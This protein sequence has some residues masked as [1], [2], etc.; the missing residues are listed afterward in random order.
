MENEINK[1]ILSTNGT[2]EKILIRKAS[3]NFKLIRVA[4]GFELCE[5]ARLLYISSGF[6]SQ[7]ESGLR[8]LP[9]K[10]IKKLAKLYQC[11]ENYLNELR[12]FIKIN[13]K[14]LKNGY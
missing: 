1:I 13:R 6:L 10:Y 14:E 11:S 3:Y 5:V 8:P 9:K 7:C 2:E 4:R 12:Y